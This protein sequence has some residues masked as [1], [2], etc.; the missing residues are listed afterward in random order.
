[1]FPL[2]IKQTAKDFRPALETRCQHIYIV[3]TIDTVCL[4]ESMWVCVGTE[5]PMWRPRAVVCLPF[6]NSLG[7]GR[8][9]P[10]FQ[11]AHS[12]AHA[13][14]HTHS[15][16]LRQNHSVSSGVSSHTALSAASISTEL[17]NTQLLL[18]KPFN[19][20]WVN[21]GAIY[22]NFWSSLSF[23]LHTIHF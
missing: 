4:Y 1:M 21:R 3:M 13:L 22:E 16:A 12:S 11:R 2:H 23:Y 10:A 8:L 7:N 19:P 20:F 18:F 17:N 15:S 6:F 9:G 5:Y 14:P